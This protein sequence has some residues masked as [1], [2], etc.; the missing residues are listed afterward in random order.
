[1]KSYDEVRRSPSLLREDSFTRGILMNT[2]PSI[3]T[4]ATRLCTA[5]LAVCTTIGF[6]SL[7]ARRDAAA[8]TIFV[9]TT[10]QKISDSGGCSLQE[11]IWAS[12]LQ[13]S[14]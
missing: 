4:L 5:V 8:A 13:L 2:R 7:L 6:A 14:A 12:R 11:A 9:T 1:M 3:A 10:Q